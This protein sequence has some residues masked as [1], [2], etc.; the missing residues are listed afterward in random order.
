MRTKPHLVPASIVLLVLVLGG[1]WSARSS[2]SDDPRN[3]NAPQQSNASGTSASGT[4]S[5]EGS[6][7]TADHDAEPTA[8]KL[9]PLPVGGVVVSEE[10]FVLTV[11]GAGRAEAET[12]SVL[13]SSVGEVVRRVRVRPGDAIEAGQTLVE[14]AR[15]PF[16]LGLEE[17]E[18]RLARAELDFE[19]QLFNDSG[20]DEAKRLRVAHRTGKTEA[21]LALKRAER[22]LAGTR[23]RA[24]FT[25]R[26]VSVDANPGQRVQPN[27]PLVTVLDD[28]KIRLPIEVLESD[29]ARLEVGA[30]ARV[31]FPAL[32][33]RVFDGAVSALGAEVDPDRGMA[34]VYVE[35]DNTDGSIRPG[36]YAEV[37]LEAGV[38]PDRIAIP[39][40]AVLERNRRLVVFRAMSG[41][42][43]WTYVETGMETDTQ[44]EILSGIAATDTVLVEGHL[45]LAHGAPV[46]VKLQSGRGD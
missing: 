2:E 46:K 41:R 3:S 45:T 40:D 28:R 24:P 16:Q 17:A 30:A 27:E 15:E 37:V 13:S 32:E 4:S 12:R 21:E 19:A 5:S 1:F 23:V 38:F 14:L 35:L 44:I 6:D 42:A 9:A 22:D 18:S 26:V 11:F 33:G 34:L 36:M 10:P 20:A 29:F 25:G 8:R 31:R 39:R 7:A 43:E